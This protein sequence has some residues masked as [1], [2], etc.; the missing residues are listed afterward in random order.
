MRQLQMLMPQLQMPTMKGCVWFH[1]V[2]EGRFTLE[3]DDAGSVEVGPGDFVLVPHGRGHLAYSDPDAK[4]ELVTE[5]PQEM[6]SERYS[7]IEY[8]TD[9][10]VTKLIC[11]VVR[12]EIRPRLVKSHGKLGNCRCSEQQCYEEAGEDSVGTD[13]D[14]PWYCRTKRAGAA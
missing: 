7:I 13:D 9:G 11:G 1:A 4:P 10:P 2:T 8:G 12:L 14:L 6:V 3:T 5:L